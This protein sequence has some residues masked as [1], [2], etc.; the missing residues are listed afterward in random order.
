MMTTISAQDPELLLSSL[1]QFGR[2]P[3]G[4]VE[5]DLRAAIARLREAKRRALA[6]ADERS[7]EACELRA[8]NQRL[9]SALKPFVDFAKR[10]ERAHPG[11]YHEQFAWDIGGVEQV[12]LRP[13]MEARAAYEQRADGTCNNS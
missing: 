6:I 10:V 9:R 12:T 7:K 1:L 13:F 8:E 2:S 3:D 4:A 5:R 11:W